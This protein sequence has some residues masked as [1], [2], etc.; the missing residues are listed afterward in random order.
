[1][2][3]RSKTPENLKI[4]GSINIAVT[5]DGFI[6][7]KDGSV[8]FL[9]AFPQTEEDD[10]GFADFVASI[11]V[12]VMGRKTFEKAVAFSKDSEW[13]YGDTRMVVWTRSELE[14]PEHL[15]KTVSTSSLAPLDLFYKLEGEGHKHAYVDG[16]VTI[17]NFLEANVIDSLSLTRVPVLL[18]SGVKLFSE[19]GQEMQLEHKETKSWP[20]GLV[21]SKYDV[22]RKGKPAKK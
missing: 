15:K 20:N 8:D 6:A 12:I 5:V 10:F 11:D 21:T 22:L 14:I 2:F 19:S 4:K 16:G 3:W 9:D 1:M 17:Q 18:G 7:A 13:Y